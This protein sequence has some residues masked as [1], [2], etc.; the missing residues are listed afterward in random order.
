MKKKNEKRI[1]LL[2]FVIHSLLFTLYSL[3]MATGKKPIKVLLLQGVPS[4]ALEIFK[5]GYEVH[6]TDT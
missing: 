5:A 1:I 6:F 3:K 4:S 2:L